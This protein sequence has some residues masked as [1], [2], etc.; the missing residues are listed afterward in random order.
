M[1]TVQSWLSGS[2]IVEHVDAGVPSHVTDEADKK[3][4]DAVKRYFEDV[5]QQLR[6]YSK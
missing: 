3:L 2:N 6:W 4:T 1:P 5:D